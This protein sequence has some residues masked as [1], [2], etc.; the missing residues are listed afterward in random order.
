MS[1]ACPG[2]R[3]G[4]SPRLKGQNKILTFLMLPKMPPR[5]GAF[6][7][8][9]FFLLIFVAIAFIFLFY[10]RGICVCDSQWG[11]DPNGFVPF[12]LPWGSS[13]C[14]HLLC[15]LISPR[16]WDFSCAE[17]TLWRFS[18]Q[19]AAHQAGAAVSAVTTLHL[20]GLQCFGVPS[21]TC[22]FLFI[23]LY[24]KLGKENIHKSSS[25]ITSVQ[26]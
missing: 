4:I 2:L 21:V 23:S 20:L 19:C 14:L 26:I 6:S 18:L 24:L 25:F 17:G 13:L 7:K 8:A 16:N 1:S 5:Q 12:E 9:F 11:M 3:L 22:K 15:I 10:V